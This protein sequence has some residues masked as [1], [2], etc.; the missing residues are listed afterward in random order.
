[1]PTNYA[2]VS[3]SYLTQMLTLTSD[4]F[5]LNICGLHTSYYPFLGGG[6]ENGNVRISV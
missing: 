5:E 6:F 1:M 2:A 3:Y 4:I